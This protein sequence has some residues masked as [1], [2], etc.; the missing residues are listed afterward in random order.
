MHPPHHSILN[1][2]EADL[3]EKRTQK[4]HA[5]IVGIAER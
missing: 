5:F 2:D 4:V 1:D 3:D